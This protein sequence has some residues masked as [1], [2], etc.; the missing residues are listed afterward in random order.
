MSTNHLQTLALAITA[1]ILAACQTTAPPPNQFAQADENHDK[2]LSL[3]E[4]NG[5]LVTEIFSSRDAN[6][7]GKLTREEWGGSGDA[8]QEKMLRERD[9]DK[10]GVVTIDEA[11]AYGR[12]KG[13]AKKFMTAADKNKD[14]QLSQEEVQSYYGSRE[15]PPR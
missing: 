4:A 10:D 13:M 3:D 15:G 7:D 8:S 9:T 6:K 12:K 1:S 5:Y 14:G 2:S 11:L